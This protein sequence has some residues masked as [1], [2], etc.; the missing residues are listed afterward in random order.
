M[1]KDYGL[2]RKILTAMTGVGKMARLSEVALALGPD[3]LTTWKR[4]ALR[5]MVMIMVR[6]GLILRMQV[7][8]F[9]S[10]FGAGWGGMGTRE[11]IIE[12]ISACLQ[13]CDGVSPIGDILEIFADCRIWGPGER[14]GQSRYVRQIIAEAGCF[15]QYLEGDQEYVGVS[16]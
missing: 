2:R 1:S 9:H 14:D 15:R 13:E 7:G 16:L 5:Q 11:Q 10:L 4:A 6:E 8:V 12:C 3:W